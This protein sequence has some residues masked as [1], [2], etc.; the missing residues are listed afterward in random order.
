MLTILS[1][2]APTARSYEISSIF[3][4]DFSSHGSS[5]GEVG[6]VAPDM[7]CFAFVTY[8]SATLRC[9]YVRTVRRWNAYPELKQSAELVL[10]LSYCRGCVFSLLIQEYVNSRCYQFNTRPLCA[11]ARA[12]A[13]S[14][15][16]QHVT[17]VAGTRI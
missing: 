2:S 10:L 12:R 14:V 7:Y 1:V 9:M 5:S 3:H 4:L 17:I 6:G 11:H 15:Y 13:C 8:A 16:I